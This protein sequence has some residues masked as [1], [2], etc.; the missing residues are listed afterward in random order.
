[1]YVYT[2]NMDK[3]NIINKNDLMEAAN[4]VGFNLRKTTRALTQYYDSI[5][6]EAGITANQ[7]T[8]LMIIYLMQPMNIQNLAEASGTERTTLARNLKVM[9][10]DELI[11]IKKGSDRREKVIN[12]SNKGEN[13]LS[14]SFEMWRK[15]QH[16][17]VDKIG[18]DK[19]KELRLELKE[20]VSFSKE[21]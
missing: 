5:I 2:L 3:K 20:I 11:N 19:W 15:A 6:K 9:E 21:K 4:C 10:R 1:M 8:L 14:K 7:N 18:E 16:Y 17:L 12:I 13:V